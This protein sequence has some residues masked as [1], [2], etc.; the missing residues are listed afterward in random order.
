MV[1]LWR[2]SP[3]IAQDGDFHSIIEHG[4]GRWVSFTTPVSVQHKLATPG[5]TD[6][7]LTFTPDFE[8]KS[9]RVV[10]VFRFEEIG[11]FST[12]VRPQL[13]ANTNIQFIIDGSP[14]QE[15][16][17]QKYKTRLEPNRQGISFLSAIPKAT[18]EKIIN[19]RTVRGLLYYKSKGSND[20][21]DVKS[22]TLDAK[23][24]RTLDRLYALAK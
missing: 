12:T 11:E 16:N 20:K 8:I 7:K 23:T 21:A 22:F 2:I 3:L 15:F 6:Y 19:A 10:Y 17:V 4:P 9:D 14:S 5:L 24:L 1:F 18:M 13:P